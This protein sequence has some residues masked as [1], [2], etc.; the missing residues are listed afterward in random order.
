M[1][2]LNSPN[3][4]RENDTPLSSDCLS[5]LL[6]LNE[7]ECSLLWQT[8]RSIENQTYP[9]WELIIIVPDDVFLATCELHSILTKYYIKQYNILVSSLPPHKITRKASGKFISFIVS[10]DILDENFVYSFFQQQKNN[11]S[12][13]FLYTDHKLLPANEQQAIA[14]FKP[15]WNPDYL[16]AYN[17][18]SRAAV[19]YRQD[20][21]DLSGL[22]GNDKQDYFHQLIVDVTRNYQEKEIYH[23]AEILFY[24]HET[25]S[26]G[27][28]DNLPS[29]KEVANSTSSPP[30]LI[31][32]FITTGNTVYP[33]ANKIRK[34]KLDRLD[35]PLVSIIIP[36]KNQSEL[37][38]Q[39]ID[40]LLKKTTYPLF[41]LLIIDNQSDEPITLAC[42]EQLSLKDNIQILRYPHPF[43]YSA[44]NNF[45]VKQAKGSLIAFVNN[46]IEVINATWLDEMVA[47]ASRPEIGCVG[48]KLYFP[49]GTIQHGGVILG[50]KGSASHAHKHFPGDH[51]GY[52]NRLSVVHNVSAV[53]AACLV[54]RKELFEEAGG[55]DAV[56]LKVAYN[57]VDLCLKVL[58]LGYRNLWTPYAELIHYESKSRGKKRSWWQ[59]RKLRKETRF[60]QKKWGKLLLNDP[61][62]NPNLTLDCEDF[63]PKN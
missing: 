45:A 43:N 40:S 31:D 39:C 3:K 60:L 21:S 52:F 7:K 61:C 38:T 11:P 18:I 46:D 59:R 24:L 58:A 53:T 2:N 9:C 50:I 23:S 41:E 26:K 47:Q 13:R 28:K 35:K 15:D 49:D 55:F 5:I 44:I 54:M 19:F 20:V 57:D 4:D 6:F 48:A 62:Y 22:P 17:Y 27:D 16:H 36:T 30:S 37:L 1:Q 42:L 10:G 25:G 34:L 12:L 51:P 63:S 56:N 33:I 14:N 29:N 32:Y 8:L